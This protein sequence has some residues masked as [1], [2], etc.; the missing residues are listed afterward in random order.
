MYVHDDTMVFFSVQ[1]QSQV[2]PTYSEG[3]LST[4]SGHLTLFLFFINSSM[5]FSPALPDV[6]SSH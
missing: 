1:N 4:V 3:N 6:A 2:S 5:L